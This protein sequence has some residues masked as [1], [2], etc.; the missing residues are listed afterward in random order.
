MA[1]LLLKNKKYNITSTIFSFSCLWTPT[2][3]P[4][5]T[6]ENRIKQTCK[7]PSQFSRASKSFWLK[8]NRKWKCIKCSLCE[9]PVFE[10]G[11]NWR[12]RQ[13]GRNN[14]GEL[15]GLSSLLIWFG[16][17][18]VWQSGKHKERERQICD[19]IDAHRDTE[20]GKIRPAGVVQA[21]SSAWSFH[22]KSGIFRPYTNKNLSTYFSLYLSA[23]HD[24]RQTM[25]TYA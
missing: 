11:Y 1:T 21:F 9:S 24:V 10:R 22:A 14:E 15:V 4:S 2:L 25:S 23:C 20:I 13:K 6:E 3:S 12:A 8:M 18:L 7:T 17:R 19:V 5:H 16:D